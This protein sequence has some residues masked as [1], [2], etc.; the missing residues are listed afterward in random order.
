[1]TTNFV[2]AACR[3][4]E[5]FCLREFLKG[6]R[7][8]LHDMAW[9]GRQNQSAK[10]GF[11]CII[12]GPRGRIRRIQLPRGRISALNVNLESVTLSSNTLEDITKI[13]HDFLLNMLYHVP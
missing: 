13:S 3:I 7:L 2:L 6:I 9:W 12:M 11:Y 1:M 4:W 8:A 5:V 10:S